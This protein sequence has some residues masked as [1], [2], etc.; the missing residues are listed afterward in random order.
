MPVASMLT[1]VQP[2]SRSQSRSSISS[3]VFVPKLRTSFRGLW[4]GT[5]DEQAGDNGR[6]VYVEST[7]SFDDQFH[8]NLQGG[9]VIAA[10]WYV[11]KLPCVLPISGCDKGW[12]LKRAPVSLLLGV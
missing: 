12:Y 6:L 10:P 2:F 7:T 8:L 5:A 3:R 1:C 4:A 11:E 9:R